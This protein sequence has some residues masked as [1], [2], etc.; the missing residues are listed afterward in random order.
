MIECGLRGDYVT[1]VVFLRGSQ[2]DSGRA[3]VCKPME[4]GPVIP[5]ASA[6]TAPQSGTVR[7][8]TE[9]RMDRYIRIAVYGVGGS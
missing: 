5:T 3:G 1:K 9:H 7:H 2:I 6:G 4:T 8:V